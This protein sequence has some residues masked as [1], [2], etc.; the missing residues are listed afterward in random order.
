MQKP[1]AYTIYLSMGATQA[2]FSY[3]IF[4][5]LAVYYVQVVSMNSL[6]L[7][8]VGTT[9]ELTILLF[10]IPTGVVADLY[11]RRL[12]VIIGFALIGICFVIEGWVPLFAAIL[13]A[14]FIRGIGETFISGAASAWAADEL[15]EA[16]VGRAYVRYG[17]ASLAGGFAGILL[18]TA[19]GAWRLNLPI[20][21][22]GALL[23]GLSLTLALIMPEQGF[24]PVPRSER[25]SWRASLNDMAATTRGGLHIVRLQ[26]VV[27]MFV[28]VGVVFGA[29][30]EGFDRLWEAHFLIDIGFPAS[31]ALPPVVWIGAI[32]AGAMLL[33]ILVSEGLLRRL[34]LHD[35]RA[36][37]RTL[38][39]ATAFLIIA[40]AVFGLAR[41]F[42]LATAAYW[43]AA[44]VRTLQYP[45]AMTWVNRNIPS[46]VRATVLSM[47]S[48]ADALGQIGGGPLVGAIGLRSLR[49]AITLSGLMLTPALFLYGR[50]L[51]LPAVQDAAA[52]NE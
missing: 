25:A 34:D 48:Q 43:L 24:T 50:R 8:L 44:S 10:E 29:F 28:L 46:H 6:Q 49:A 38:M 9:I 27:L 3:M 33:G 39:G 12:A 30:S 52:P 23:L 19:L 36:L 21:L 22:G 45:I 1:S 51:R 5:V 41:G 20:W 35:P 15:G 26:P 18:G 40:V 11:S 31:P 37:G 42:A 4:T 14:E 2:L 32:G 7:V 17:Q 16:R 47:V 13:V